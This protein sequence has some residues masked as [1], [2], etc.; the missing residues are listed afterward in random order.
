[1]TSTDNRVDSIAAS[2]TRLRSAIISYNM[3][4]V[5]KWPLDLIRND[6]CIGNDLLCST[7]LATVLAGGF[8]MIWLIDLSN[9]YQWLDSSPVIDSICSTVW[10]EVLGSCSIVRRSAV[11]ISIFA[12]AVQLDLTMQQF[13]QVSMLEICSTVQLEIATLCSTVGCSTVGIDTSCSTVKT[14]ISSRKSA[15]QFTQHSYQHMSSR[16]ANANADANANVAWINRPRA[17]LLTFKRFKCSAKFVCF[18]G[19]W[20]D[21]PSL[22]ASR[23]MKLKPRWKI[24]VVDQRCLFLRVTVWITVPCFGVNVNLILLLGLVRVYWTLLGIYLFK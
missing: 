18:V 2:I 8:V 10:N 14:H 22:F 15:L 3:L 6:D 23:S 11:D 20:N 21:R 24:R 16:N 7:L 19:F 5:Y 9:C 13:T 4:Q 12:Y 1:M 17:R